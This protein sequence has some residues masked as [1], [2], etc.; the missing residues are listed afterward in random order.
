M[1]HGQIYLKS[2]IDVINKYIKKNTL[3]KNLKIIL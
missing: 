2:L 1:R 3:N